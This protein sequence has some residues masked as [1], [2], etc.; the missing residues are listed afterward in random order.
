MRNPF[1]RATKAVLGA[2]M[3]CLT[4]LA[5]GPPAGAQTPTSGLVTA[6]GTQL[7]VNGQP[8]KFAGYNIPCANSL[9]LTLSQFSYYLSDIQ[10]NSGANVVRVW[11]FQS[12]GGPGNWASFDSVINALQAQGMRAIVTL[13]NE[14]STCD[15]PSASTFYKTVGWYQTGYLSPEGGYSLSFHDYAVDVAAHYANNPTVAFWQLVN[16]AQDPS[17][18]SSGNLTCPNETTATDALRTFSDNMTTAIHAVDPH[19]LVDLGTLTTGD[20]GIQ[21]DADYTYVHAGDLGLCEYH[22]Y[23]QPATAMP[24]ALAGIVSDCHSLGKPVFVGESGI[25]ANVGP[26]GTPNGTCT[27]WPSC[28]PDPITYDTLDQRASFFQAKIQAANNDGVAGYVI[29]FDSPYY[30][31][32]TDGYSISDGDPT[33]A[34]LQQ[35]LQPYPTGAPTATPEAPW[36]AGLPIIAVAVLGGGYVMLRRR[37]RT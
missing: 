23:G 28:S 34:V 7:E 2:V 20:C 11:F 37:S 24:S 27:P 35:A 5:S 25:P 18:D 8:W 30:T 4:L 32:T 22:D 17:Y 6:N 36:T 3:L 21:N 26:T 1:G 12:E 14:T 9:D 19:H 13:T 33:M 29:W 16:E 31:D 15:E 10:Q